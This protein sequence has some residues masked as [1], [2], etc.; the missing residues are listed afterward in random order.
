[1]I[2]ERF[3]KYRNNITFQNILKKK[4]YFKIIR[5]ILQLTIALKKIATKLYR[6]IA[7]NLVTSV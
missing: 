7:L 2:S 5:S 1:M 6:Q 4:L 3:V